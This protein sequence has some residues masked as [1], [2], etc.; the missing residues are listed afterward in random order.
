[1]AKK[2]GARSIT[3]FEVP[4]SALNKLNIK[5]FSTKCELKKFI[6]GGRAG[7]LKHNYDGVEGGDV[8]ESYS[9]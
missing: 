4:N 9:L 1:M 8:Y 2:D 6:L 3:K 5:T 7:T